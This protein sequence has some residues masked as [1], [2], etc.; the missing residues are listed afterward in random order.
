METILEPRRSWKGLVL[1]VGPALLTAFCGS[2]EPADE[3]MAESQHEQASLAGSPSFEYDPL[4]PRPLPNNWGLG[5]VWGVA[6][7]SQDNPWILHGNSDRASELLRQEGKQMAPP[8]VQF[9]PEGN[10][11]QAWGGPGD[12]YDWMQQTF[13]SEHG[14]F[15]DHEDNVWVVGG[16]TSGVDG[17]VAL[18]FTAT[19]EF[20]LQIGVKGQTNG[21][22][23]QRLLGGPTTAA[24]D[25]ETNE[26]FIADGYINQRVVVFDA[27]TGAY[28]RHWGAYGKPPDDGPAEPLNPDGPAPQRWNAAHCVRIADDGLVYVC[29]R[30][31]SRV[32]VFETDGTFVEEVFLDRATPAPWRYDV[33]VNRYVSRTEPGN[34]TG[35][36]SMVAFSHDPDQ[37]YLYV[38]SASSYRKIY[39]LE[40][41]TLELVNEVDTSGGHHEMSVDSSGNIYTVDGFARRPERYLFTTASQ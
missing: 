30:S 27:V 22:D 20:L 5:E 19:G 25:P 21:S 13:G 18:K 40:R 7:D 32:H 33:D 39:I 31:H 9:D 10:V 16:G 34:G 2:P 14:L 11:L 28:K 24:V 37:R 4:W 15:I 41:R 17:G 36:A 8:V 3:G 23:D 29:D 26:V 38:G 6:V 35:A 12:G 1:L